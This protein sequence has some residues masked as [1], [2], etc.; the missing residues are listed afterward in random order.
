MPVLESA[1]TL[2]PLGAPL[3]ALFVVLGTAAAVLVF[4][5]GAR[6]EGRLG[7]EL[8]VVLL[9][10][11][12]CGALGAKLA[13][14]WRYVDTAA[15]PSPL[16]LVLR[17]G[18]SVLGG[19]AGAYLGALATKR[20]IGYRQGTGDLFAPAVALGIGVGRFGCLL[21]ETPGVPTGGSW[22]TVVDAARAA[23]IPGFPPRWIG[24]PLHPS[25]LYEIPFHFAMAGIL[26]HLRAKGALRDDLF[27]LYLLAYAL[28]RFALEFV[29]GN[30]VV[31]HG[32]TRSQLFLIPSIPLLGALL[33][34]R[35]RTAD[36]P[37]QTE[38]AR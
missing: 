24:L 14:V 25:F 37:Q 33:L 30:P 8:A 21:T 35:L 38:P 6:R 29:R 28:A 11:L 31:W 9:G 16:G 7:D 13:V 22:G 17:G 10:A 12:V 4:F 36:L 15:A 3:H 2:D 20:L 5:H 27:K 19:L 18:Q 32:L 34:R 26:F 23:R 1:A